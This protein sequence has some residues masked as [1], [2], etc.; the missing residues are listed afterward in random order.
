MNHRH[1]GEQENDLVFDDEDWR[2]ETPG[3]KCRMERE[4]GLNMV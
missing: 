3:E 4:M 1:R 2:R